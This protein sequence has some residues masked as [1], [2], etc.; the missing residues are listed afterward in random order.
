MKSSI[1]QHPGSYG[2]SA[3]DNKGVPR[4]TTNTSKRH[5][6]RPVKA[7]DGSGPE[8]GE[9]DSRFGSW[10][11]VEY[12]QVTAISARALPAVQVTR[13]LEG[14]GGGWQRCHSQRSTD[15]RWTQTYQS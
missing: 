14:E 9:F 7:L 12:C 11:A 8:P 15:V 10:A 6:E 2:Q 1:A 3:Y 5:S 13:S 4:H